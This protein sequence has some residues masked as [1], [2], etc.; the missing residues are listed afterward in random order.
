MHD[1][2][3]IA[4]PNDAAPP[5]TLALCVVSA[6][7]ARHRA[8]RLLDRPSAW[9]D[10]SVP[11]SFDEGATRLQIEL[12]L[13]DPAVVAFERIAIV[14]EARGPA[15]EIDAAR[16][17]LFSAW[18]LPARDGVRLAML[19]GTSV[20]QIT[21]IDPAELSGSRLLLR[22]R[23]EPFEPLSGADPVMAA[24]A[25]PEARARR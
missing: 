5:G 8:R 19:G 11:L 20:V 15:V 25:R 24:F 10:I 16:L 12:A 4:P 17:A 7:V 6:P 23:C 1:P 13:T 22:L 2:E 14:S 9:T 18:A 3:G 21:G